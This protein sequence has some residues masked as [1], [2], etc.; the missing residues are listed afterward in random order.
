[1]SEPWLLNYAYCTHRA[2]LVPIIDMHFEDRIPQFLE[3][4]FNQAGVPQL[5][6]F[7]DLLWQANEELNLVS[8]KMQFSDLLD[9]HVID[10]LLPLN[11]FPKNS[12]NV[13]D[14][15]TG[16]GLPAIIY[17]IQFP[18]IQFQLFEKS[19]RKQ[20]FLKR[21]LNI[22]KNIQINNEIPNVLKNVDLIMARGFKPLDVILDVSRNYY[23]S[24]GKYFL[25]KARREKIDE[26]ISLAH[27]KFKDLKILIQALK[28]PV[29]EVERHLLIIN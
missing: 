17:A 7:V 21:C 10:C 22:T 6:S 20:E 23:E 28:S 25:L 12:K 19:I 13:A 8:R 24:N 5:K 9:N 11:S 15:G 1:M 3:L 16:G 2:S 27:K 29:L 26:E 18:E 4:G 14:F